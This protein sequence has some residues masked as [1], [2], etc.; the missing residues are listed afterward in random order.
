METP[1]NQ[2]VAALLDSLEDL[3]Q[4]AELTNH[5][6][7]EIATESNERVDIL[8]EQIGAIAETTDA[9]V[10]DLEKI[11]ARVSDDLDNLMIGELSEIDEVESDT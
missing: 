7:D 9:M 11:E 3:A 6:I 4:A 10:A 2:E 8:I 1:N 5:E